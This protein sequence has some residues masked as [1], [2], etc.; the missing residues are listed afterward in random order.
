MAVQPIVAAIVA[1][2]DISYAPLDR[3]PFDLGFGLVAYGGGRPSTDRW[4]EVVNY[5]ALA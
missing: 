5:R 1:C 4:R 2:R 3:F